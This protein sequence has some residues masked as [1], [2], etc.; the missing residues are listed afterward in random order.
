MRGLG[1]FGTKQKC[2]QSILS[3]PDLKRSLQQKKKLVMIA[4]KKVTENSKDADRSG[5]ADPDR[6]SVQRDQEHLKHDQDQR[7]CHKVSHSV[8][9][10]TQRVLQKKLWKVKVG[11][12]YV[13]LLTR[14][15]QISIRFSFSASW[16]RI[17]VL[18]C[19][20]FNLSGASIN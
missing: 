9:E 1:H 19:N 3:S 12:T 6:G 4:W 8:K 5:V 16:S 17:S 14:G 13:K 15:G 20:L 2:K 7:E 11:N 18:V 10:S